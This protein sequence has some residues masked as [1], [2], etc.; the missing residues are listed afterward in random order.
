MPRPKVIA[1]TSGVPLIERLPAD[2]TAWSEQH[3]T[4]WKT[5]LDANP[6]LHDGPIWSVVEAD[7]ARLTVRA[8]RY[9]RLAVQDDATIGW[10][11]VRQLGVKGLVIGHDRAGTP[12]V[13]L[14]RRG[15][16]TRI[17]AGMWEIAPGRR[18][19]SARG[20][21]GRFDHRSTWPGVS[22]GTRAGA[23]R[24]HPANAR[25]ADR[26]PDRAVG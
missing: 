18:G 11:G 21:N 22:G 24:R 5:M 9:K 20:T 13:L 6:R 25:R 26:R 17:Y 14:A 10:L 4:V 19:K 23:A 3:E 1:L 16:E 8:D 2:A 15:S 12:R 7:A